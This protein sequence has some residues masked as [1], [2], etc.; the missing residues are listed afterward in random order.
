MN[1][2]VEMHN[3]CNFTCGYC[4]NKDMERN[5]EF[6][7]DEVWDKILH[8][9][10]VPYKN[11]NSFCPPTFIGHKD[12]EPLIDKRIQLRLRELSYAVPDMKIDIYSNGV[13]LPKW[14]ERGQDFIEFLASL[15]NKVRYLLSYHPFNHDNSVNDYTKVIEYLRDVLRNPPP[16]IE[17][18]TVSHKSKW[19]SEQLQQAWKQTWEGLP[20]T[21][22]CNCS[23]NPWT[24]RIEEGTI[25]FNGCP[26]ADFGHWFF[27]VTGNIIACCLDLEEEVILGN[28][29]K[30]DPEV[31]FNRTETFYAQQRET[32]K[33]S[34][35]P[36]YQVCYDCFGYKRDDLIQLE[37]KVHKQLSEIDWPGEKQGESY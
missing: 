3:Y 32:K 35:K 9:Y 5:R 6:M 36:N 31:M 23:I 21:V 4:P 22:H 14:R 25:R 12:S 2:Q 33:Q 24:G 16:N 15:P 37:P 19:V 13:L 7:T 28:V 29:L 34:C 8:N 20:I 17:F 18:I 10:I 26:Y 30:D 11:Y 1:F 27:G